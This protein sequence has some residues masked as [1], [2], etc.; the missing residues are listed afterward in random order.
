M[1]K[2]NVA[3]YEEGKRAYW[4]YQDISDNPYN[5][6]EESNQFSWERG[7]SEASNEKEDYWDRHS[8]NAD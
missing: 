7:W 2:L 1:F 3:A 8:F 6:D 4:K 5:D